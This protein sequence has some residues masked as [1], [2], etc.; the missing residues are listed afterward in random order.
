[1][2]DLGGGPQG[3]EMMRSFTRI[4]SFPSSERLRKQ[5]SRLRKDA[6]FLESLSSNHSIEF[7]ASFFSDGRRQV[8]GLDNASL[9]G[10]DMTP[11]WVMP[12]AVLLRYLDMTPQHAIE[13]LSGMH[14]GISYASRGERLCWLGRHVDVN[15]LPGSHAV[16]PA[17]GYGWLLGEL[18]PRK[19][20]P[21]SPIDRKPIVAKDPSGE[22][23][24]EVVT[25][26]G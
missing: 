8:V 3:G 15:Y 20:C 19:P 26:L 10:V 25:L 4:G 5:A 22:I 18:P 24:A 2:D 12:W 13:W 17:C 16:C 1:M 11:E 21:L 23:V 14:F 9:I 7:Y 6:E